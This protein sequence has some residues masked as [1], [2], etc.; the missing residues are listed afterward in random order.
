MTFTPAP[1]TE[2]LPTRVT[3]S[4]HHGLMAKTP[5]VIP[6]LGGEYCSGTFQSVTLYSITHTMYL[7]HAL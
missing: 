1:S 3:R 7:H 6:S 2:I 4:G 5:T